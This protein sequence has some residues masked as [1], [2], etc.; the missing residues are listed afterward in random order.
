MANSDEPSVSIDHLLK[1]ES[2]WHQ[3]TTANGLRCLHIPMP[4]GDRR[5]QITALVGTG[6]RHEPSH[7]AGISHLLEHMMFRGSKNYPTFADLSVAFENFGGEWNA[8]TGHEYTEFYYNGTA[9]NL[10]ES[11]E[12]FA[13]FMIRPQLNDLEIERRIV[14]RELEGELNENGVSTDPDYHIA[15][16]IFVGQSMALPI[17]GT[18]DTLKVISK[19]DLWTWFK[20]RYIPKDSVICVVGGDRDTVKQTVEQ[21]FDSWKST[22]STKMKSDITT[23]F[24]GP[25]A[26]WIENSDNE[27]QVQMSFLCEGT[28]S[29][30]TAA[31]EL[32]SRILSDGFS[33][34]LTRRIREELGLVYD[35]SSS[36]HQYDGLGLF[37]INASVLRENLQPLFKEIFAV[38]DKLKS[39]SIA[40]DELS[41]HKRRARV[42]LDITTG[43]PAALAWRASWA[44]LSSTEMKLSQ[45]AINYDCLSTV[46]LTR[47]AQE[48]FKP[49]HLC[50]VAL[51][52]K[53]GNIAGD[54][55][56]MTRQWD[57]HDS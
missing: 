33:S 23:K 26:F 12:L 44:L 25:Q 50:V 11:I 24:T 52:P 45:W 22:P 34:R 39:G 55:A 41:R 56:K 20:D 46:D 31:Y 47:I 30:K 9:N 54:L 8:A 37:N 21:Q 18:N 19:E 4:H 10:V 57:G 40:S 42:D 15:T 27:Y 49:E 17:I 35:I 16:K 48:I 3:W 38:L 29:S 2:N 53:E 28:G 5:F 43:E 13:D 32:L 51:G 36:L 7:L 1:S 14:Q 6:S